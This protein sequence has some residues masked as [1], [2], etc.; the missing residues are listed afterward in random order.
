MP[1][2]VRA[3]AIL[4]T[5]PAAQFAAEALNRDL[6]LLVY[7]GADGSFSLVEDDGVTYAYERGEYCR[8]ELSYD[9]ATGAVTIGARRGRFN[10][11]PA[12]REV[13]VRWMGSEPAETS[14]TYTGDAVTVAR[15]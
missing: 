11:M 6:T 13:T 14:V 3:G 12:E 9:D 2:F 10:G 15:P 4:P 8:I 1:L 7:P 5:G